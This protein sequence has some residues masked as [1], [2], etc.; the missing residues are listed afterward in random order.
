MRRAGS[1]ASTP[2]WAS[3]R[4]RPTGRSSFQKYSADDFE[5]RVPGRARRHGD[6]P[7]DVPEGVVHEGLQRHRAERRPAR[8]LPRQ[9]DRQ[10][11]LGSARRRGGPAPARG[12]PRQVRPQGRQALHGRVAQRLARLEADRSGGAPVPRQVRRARHPQRPRPQGPDDLAAR[13]GR[14]RRHRHRPRGDRL[15]RRAQLHRRAL[16]HPADRGLLLHRDAGPNVYAG[17]A[18]VVGRPH[19]CASA[20]LRR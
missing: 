1:S 2:T 8:A 17:I 14:V 12:R 4:R 6:P 10:R 20:V 7:V 15:Q 13:Q 11:P 9:A 19:A 5:G 16:R 3:D 18:V